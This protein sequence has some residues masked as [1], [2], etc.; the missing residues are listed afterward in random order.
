T[1]KSFIRPFALSHAPLLRMGLLKLAQEKYMLLVDMHH[2]ISDGMST[3]VLVQ[4]FSALYEGKNLPGIN[5]HYKDY[6]EWQNRE[7]VNKKIRAQGDYWEKVYEGEI[8]VLDLPADYPRPVVKS[9]AGD[10]ITFKIDHETF[11]ALKVLALEMGATPYIVLLALYN[12]LLAK[13]SGQEEIIIGSPVAGRS[14]ADLEKIIGMFVNTLAFRNYPSGEKRFIDFLEEVKEITLKGFENQEYPYEDLIEKIIVNRDVSRNPLFDT[15]FVL[16]NTGSQ[17]I[18]LPGL[19][20]APFAYENKTA[21]FDLVLSG[22]EEDDELFFTFEYCTKLFKKETIERFIIYFNNIITHIVENKN[23]RISGLT[24]LTEAEKNRILFEFNNTGADYPQDKT[25]QQLFAEQVERTADGIAVYGRGQ[26]GAM[27]ITYHQLHEQSNRLAHLLIEKGVGPDTIVAIMMERSVEMIIGILGILKSGGAYLPLDTLYPKERI[28]YILKDSSARIMVGRAEEQKSGRAEFVFSCFFSTSTL[29]RF[30]D[31]DSSNLAY[32]I[33]T[34]GST[35]KPKG[36]MVRHRNVVNLVNGLNRKIYNKYDT[37]LNVC[38]ISPF[39]F[40]AS[41][42]QIFAALLLG[43]C[44]FVVPEETRM[45]GDL[46]LHYYI[47]NMIDISDGTPLHLRLLLENAGKKITPLPVKHFII[48]GDALPMRTA[49]EFLDKFNRE[50]IITNIYG[51]TE[52]TVDTTCYDITPGTGLAETIPIGSP[53]PNCRVYILDKWNELQGVNILGELCISGHGVSQGYLNRPEL[54]AEKFY[55]H[56]QISLHHHFPL[57]RTG[58]LARWLPDGNIDFLGRIDHQVKIRGFRIEL[59]E[60]ESELSKHKEIKDVVVIARQSKT[61]ENY[62]CAYMVSRSGEQLS[63]SDLRAYLR[64]QLPDYMIPA[65]FVYLDRIPL[66][67][68]GKVDRRALPQPELKA[69]QNYMAPRNEIETKLV[70][71]WSEILGRESLP[72]SE[73]LHGAP[74]QTSIGIDDNFFELGGHSLKATLL[75][76]KIHKVFDVVVPLAEI[77]KTPRIREI[78]GYIIK[79]AHWEYEQIEAAEKKEYYLLSSAQKRLYF[80]QQ[81][82]KDGITYNITAIMIVAGILDKK[83]LEHSI[84]RLI[85]RHESLRTSIDVIAE[86]PVQRIHEGVAFAIENVGEEENEENSAKD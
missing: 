2:I 6:A 71:L 73:S 41:V 84:R 77:F 58:D 44:L 37:H 69:G 10:S 4:D 55:F 82:E 28:D 3:Q 54:T 64:Q 16:Q 49:K 68:S 38:L 70:E 74:L 13:L 36:V 31:A 5:G 11:N 12:V 32:V 48:G 65:Y 47:I 39:V 25:I 62:L 46:L 9:F 30:L 33:Y 60:I 86:E 26:T 22:S 18:E 81:M 45:F 50:I 85:E 34:S 53:M 14:H 20:L 51:P 15:M 80:L 35:G 59:G 8:P 83:R 52:C 27:V 1:I 57:Y 66:T 43:H 29:P 75:A 24:I 63:T 78:S 76:A 79:A 7:K 67:P 19:K 23:R 72:G 40:D 42:K 17:K 61:K 56:P 21:K